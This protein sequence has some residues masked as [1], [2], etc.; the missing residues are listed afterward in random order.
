MT[1]LASIPLDLHHFGLFALEVFVDRFHK[2]I[3]Q[4]LDIGFGVAQPVFG[5]FSGLLQLLRFVE[6]VT[7]PPDPKTL[8]EVAALT[9]AR[10]YEAPDGARLRAVYEELGSRVGR[11]DEEREI[12]AVFAAAGAL[13]FLG[14][15]AASALLFGRLP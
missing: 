2:A 4:L 12:T 7:V 10:F 15:G 11:E 1:E 6:R 5:Q 3:R 13:L 9:R 8:R 14:A